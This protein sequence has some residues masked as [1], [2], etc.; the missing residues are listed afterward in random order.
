[1]SDENWCMTTYGPNYHWNGDCTQCIK[2]HNCKDWPVDKPQC[3]DGDVPEMDDGKGHCGTGRCHH[4]CPLKL[5]DTDATCV[6]MNNGKGNWKKHENGCHCKCALE[7][8]C[9]LLG[10]RANKDC[11]ACENYCPNKVCPNGKQVPSQ[12][13]CSCH[14]NGNDRDACS[15]K[16]KNFAL[17]EDCNCVTK[18]PDSAAASC[19]AQGPQGNSW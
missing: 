7:P 17:D 16:G 3:A 18:C 2:R 14:C 15:L 1:M 6:A 9:Q 12:N 10:M 13:D 8:D 4:R 5:D 19:A 11:T